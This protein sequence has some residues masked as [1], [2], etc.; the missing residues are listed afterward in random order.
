M[1]IY[2]NFNTFEFKNL[3]NTNGLIYLII[4]GFKNIKG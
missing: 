2:N 3:S 1:Q 4:W